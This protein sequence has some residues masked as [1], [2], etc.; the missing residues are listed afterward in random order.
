MAFKTTWSTH[1][2]TKHITKHSKEWWNKQCT[3]CINAYHETG[4]IQSWKAF[5][6]AVRNTKRSF[7]NQKIQEIAPSNKRLWDLMNWVKKKNLP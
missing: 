2:M 5:K 3:D 6:T 7:F 4:D 1:S